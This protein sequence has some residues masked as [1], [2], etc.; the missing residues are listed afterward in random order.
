MSVRPIIKY[1]PEFLQN[2]IEYKWIAYAF[3]VEL[4]E[5]RQKVKQIKNAIFVRSTDLET[6][7]RWEN[8]YNIV[9][10]GSLKNRQ[11][12]VFSK[13]QTQTPYSITALKNYLT[14][15]T[16]GEENIAWFLNIN[17]LPTV[18][19]VSV[20]I[21][22]LNQYAFHDVLQYLKHTVPLDYTYTVSI[23]YFTW[24]D[25]TDIA[26]WQNLIAYTWTETKEG[27]PYLVIQGT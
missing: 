27:V 18:K 25:Y 11:D 15:K 23:L 7:T 4:S 6:I 5:V 24:Q 12:T 9:P 8:D 22:V 17:H 21:D 3:D 13:I 10:S 19:R 1:I 2:I 26:N 20:Q 14:E 16:G